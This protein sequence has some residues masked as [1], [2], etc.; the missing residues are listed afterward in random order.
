MKLVLVT[1]VNAFHKDV[2]KL[3]KKAGI[4]S[5]SESDIDGHKNGS[6]LV[7]TNTWF[8]SEK[9]G[10]ESS[11]FFSFTEE[12]AIDKLFKLLKEFND[13]LETNNPIKAV[14]LPIERSL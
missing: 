6:S 4:E 2:V 12:D 14:V 10:N 5:F 13:N 11:M 7:M 9:G 8:P 3:F 1:S